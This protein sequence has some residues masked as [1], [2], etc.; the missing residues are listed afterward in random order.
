MSEPK[1]PHCGNDPLTTVE[2]CQR[3]G[4]EMGESGQDGNGWNC[5]CPRCSRGS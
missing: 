4:K 5:T 2:F 1:C 3:C